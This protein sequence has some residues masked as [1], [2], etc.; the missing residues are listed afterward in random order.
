MSGLE[1]TPF[2][3]LVV[4]MTATYTKSVSEDDIKLFAILSGDTNPIHL[5]EEY[6][7]TTPF[8]GCI[9]H[10][11]MCA[12]IISAAVATKFPGPG[13]IYA[14]QEMRFKKPV[15][16]GDTLTAHL[17]LLEKKR[18]GNIVLIQ[19]EIKNQNGETVF[20]GV[21]TVVAPTE[22]VVAKPVELPRV[23]LFD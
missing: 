12:V 11:A 4:G 17:E 10:G 15:R 9:A 21:S 5:D 8:G 2:D 7:K 23:E 18:R 19:N 20:L 3:E 6:A 14:G 13:S 22:K 1:N 16:P